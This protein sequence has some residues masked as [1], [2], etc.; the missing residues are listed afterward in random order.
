MYHSGNASVQNFWDIPISAQNKG[1]PA[2]PD[3]RRLNLSRGVALALAGV[4][5]VIVDT[6]PVGKS[7]YKR[8]P[9]M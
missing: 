4:T 6:L 9:V 5:P 1:R 2:A 8:K 3:A 7:E